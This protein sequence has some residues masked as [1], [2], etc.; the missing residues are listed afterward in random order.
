M[1]G[2]G[3]YMLKFDDQQ[4]N[5]DLK[6]LREKEEEELVQIA[7]KRKEMAY[8]DLRDTI[9]STDALA[10]VDE[11]DAR[12]SR[13]AGFKLTG[14]ELFLGVAS[15][16][17]TQTR[18]LVR[19]LTD[20][21][22]NISQYLVSMR[23]LKKAWGRYNDLK[24]TSASSRS[25]VDISDAALQDISEKVSIIDDV[26]ALF[27]EITDS[28]DSQKTSR[29]MEV[30]MGGAISLGVSDVHIEPQN[31]H[32]RLRYR[33]DGILEDAAT[34]DHK[35]YRSLANRVKIL[36][37]MKLNVV[38]NAQDGRFTIEYHDTEIEIRVS[39]TPGPY[40]EGIVMR[41]LDPSNINVGLDD[42]GIE[43]VL[44]ARLK[45]EVAKP[46]GLVLNTGPTGS[47]KTTT[48]YSLIKYIY[49]PEI[50]VLTIEN[51]IE[52]HLDGIHQTQTD[53]SKDYDFAAGL[54]AAMRQDPDVILVGEI[55]DHETALAAMQAAQTGHLVLSTLHTN[56][57]AGALPRLLDL[58][59]NYATLAQSISVAVAQRL[60]RKLTDA[61]RKVRPTKDQE[62]I[63]RGV[64]RHAEMNGKDLSRFDVSSDMD[65]WIYE[66][67]PSE[68]SASGYKGRI[69]IFEA[70]FANDAIKD[71]LANK[72]TDRQVKK[73]AQDQNILTLSE[74]AVVK[75]LHGVTSYNEAMRVIDI[76]EDYVPA[77]EERKKQQEEN[78]KKQEKPHIVAQEKKEPEDTRYDIA[79]LE[80][81]LP[82]T[83][84]RK[85]EGKA[86]RDPQEKKTQ[87]K[88][89]DN[90]P[91]YEI[92]L[93]TDYLH[94]L[95]DHQRENP[96]VSIE[97][98]IH[99]IEQRL[100]RI[101]ADNKPH[102][103]FI[104]KDNEQSLNNEI[105][106][107]MQELRNIKKH[108]SLK[109]TESAERSLQKIRQ[110]IEMLKK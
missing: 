104:Q 60:V 23:S 32:T 95:E 103:I 44:L 99:D 65:M 67:V 2:N 50:K 106:V 91:A 14:Q 20:A 108:Q 96:N 72:P 66:P 75:I 10:L 35:T 63:L 4:I 58:K 13:V 90:D 24:L 68:K 88:K 28:E 84:V 56:S 41:I 89:Q 9:I 43:P 48:L 36:A 100:A 107:L 110:R 85:E 16:E 73:L 62:R 92:S 47:G 11:E 17:N 6:D 27:A 29:L 57:A 61:K 102:E 54:R 46:N 42:L 33:L 26:K 93:L 87:P 22:Y 79:Q 53:H 49:T 39:N 64:L 77:R 76:S 15:P 83:M 45:E 80:A 52:Y 38:N 74:D 94:M 30:V 1:K 98:K 8:V 31:E 55:R 105:N 51:P 70:I 81:A 21:G 37:G 69:G 18:A 101:L 5:T 86:E 12:E 7:A 34:I 97:G 78:S 82:I 109:P 40:G 19:G 3:S 25:F 71:L 59:I